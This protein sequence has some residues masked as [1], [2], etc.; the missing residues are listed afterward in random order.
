[1]KPYFCYL[2]TAANVIVD[3]DSYHCY[4]LPQYDSPFV[5]TETIMAHVIDAP[6]TGT[7]MTGQQE[8]YQFSLYFT[9]QK[10]HYEA[11]RNDITIVSISTTMDIKHG[12]VEVRRTVNSVAII[13]NRQTLAIENIVMEDFGFVRFTEICVGGGLL[14]YFGVLQNVY[15]NHH[16]LSGSGGVYNERKCFKSKKGKF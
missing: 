9:Q 6:R 8:D 7:L 2:E 16:Y 10:L 14:I 11:S 5:E 13:V 3:G 4:T 15:Y 12:T 1:M